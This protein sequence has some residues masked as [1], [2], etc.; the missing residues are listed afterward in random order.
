MIAVCPVLFIGRAQEK[1]NCFA[2]SA[3]ATPM[4]VC[5]KLVAEALHDD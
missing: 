4:V 2:P 1:T 5:R 3:V